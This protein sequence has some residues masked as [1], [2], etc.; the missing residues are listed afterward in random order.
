MQCKEASFG[1]SGECF[2]FHFVQLNLLLWMKVAKYFNHSL[3]TL[4]RNINKKSLNS[5]SKCTWTVLL[6]ISLKA[7]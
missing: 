6:D 3:G 4:V 7:F 1:S 5:K 2:Q